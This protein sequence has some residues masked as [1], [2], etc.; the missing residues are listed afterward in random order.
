MRKMGNLPGLTVKEKVLVHLHEEQM[1]EWDV[2]C[3]RELTQQAMADIIG[4]SRPHI[5]Q[6][7][8]S[9]EE[10]ELV[11]S[12]KCRIEGEKRKK[13]AYRLTEK[14]RRKAEGLKKDLLDVEVEIEKD[15]KTVEKSFSEL[16]SE[17]SL[18]I[19]ELY[20][21]LSGEEPTS[22]KE[23]TGVEETTTDEEISIEE[24][25]PPPPPSPSIEK[26][27]V[28]TEVE[29]EHLEDPSRK[30]REK[31]SWRGEA[32]IALMLT[33]SIPLA[34]L[35]IILGSPDRSGVMLCLSP[36][37][38][39]ITGLAIMAHYFSCLEERDLLVE[40]IFSGAVILNL[41]SIITVW[42]YT[43]VGDM[44]DQVITYV[45]VF[46]TLILA[47]LVPL[48]GV[49]RYRKEVTFIS[50]P[51]L[52]GHGVFS[53]L[54]TEVEFASPLALY[55][56]LAGLFMLDIGLRWH[57]EEGWWEDFLVGVGLYSL[58]ILGWF[59][60]YRAGTWVHSITIMIWMALGASGTSTRLMKK[61]RRERIYDE[62][63][64]GLPL[65]LTLIFGVLAF[66]LF[67]LSRY[68]EG[69]IELFLSS[70]FFISLFNREDIDAGEIII[71]LTLAALVGWTLM[72]VFI[73]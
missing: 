33:F 70:V 45:F 68:V 27:P 9:L 52:I 42:N 41:A 14:G 46:L 4:V 54:F 16:L 22:W 19:I 43:N 58:V 29:E 3:P 53:F 72:D 44:A 66:V 18:S 31:K 61:E 15:D 13:K 37:L 60:F 49:K 56:V 47:A 64:N 24:E 2:E 17:T 28:A 34:L 11:R 38:G 39:L 1:P 12:K 69:L 67:M 50:S 10:D 26:R 25:E 35:Y 8:I 65:A 40:Q 59:L 36:L 30:R 7:L 20:N 51:L 21:N 62:V 63:W 6:T 5:S 23:L 57:K 48:K 32:Y 71:G 73:F 55:W